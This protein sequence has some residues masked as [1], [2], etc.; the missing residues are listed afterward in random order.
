MTAEFTVGQS[1]GDYEVLSILGLGGMGKVYKVRNVISDRVEAMKVLLPDLNSHQSLADRFLREIRL[2]ASLNHPNIAA[3]RTALTYENQ[4]VMIMEFVEGETLANRIARAPISTAEAVNYSEQILS[5]LSYAHK[6]NIIHR[7][8]KPANMMLTPQGVVKLMDFGIA[9]SGTDGSLTSTGTTLGSLNYMPPEQVRGE[10][11]DA[12][13]DLYSF[14]ISLYELL[15]GKLPFQGDSQYSLMTAQLNQQPASP[16]SLRADVPPALNEIILMAMAKEPADR[17][18]SADA[19]CNALKSVPVS[20]LPS[21]GTTFAQTARPSAPMSAD[22]TLMG[23]LAPGAGAMGRMASPPATTQAAVRVPAPPV[24]P[25]SPSSIPIVPM[26]PAPAMAAAAESAPASYAPPPARSSSRG[27]W[28]AMG[29]LLGAGVLIAAGVYIPRRMKTHADPEQSNMPSQSTKDSTA[30]P[31]G[32]S[33]APVSVTTPGGSV[34]VDGQGNV[35]VQAPGVS[36]NATPDGNVNVTAPG[37]SVHAGTKPKA[38]GNPKP[39]RDGGQATAPPV[40]AGPSPEEIAKMEDE[41]DKLNI[42]ATTASRS[43]ETLRQQQQAA[44][45][46]LRGDI[47]SAADRMQMYIAKGDAAL[48][49]KDMANAQKYY[50]L[51][52]AE[53]SKVEK[54]LG[55]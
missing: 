20:A 55:H 42:R 17:F 7:D 32:S 52:D 53:I 51:A 21:Q 23:T 14:G 2:L 49:A 10:S 15:T 5:A 36:V 24:Q 22:D 41:A 27:L 37:T 38:D 28:L 9:R 11:A 16:I 40:P 18:Q 33:D 44:G 4:L 8:I 12:R 31:N 54:F 45:Y 43:V 6:H 47:A 3:L 29:S 46:N 34:S 25:R 13:S 1:V 48:K 50:D 19:F 35:S 26:A 30:K 39:S